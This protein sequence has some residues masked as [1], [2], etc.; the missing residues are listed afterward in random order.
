MSIS[1]V[2]AVHTP[3]ASHVRPAQTRNP[4]PDPDPPSKTDRL[5]AGKPSAAEG[6]VDIVDIKV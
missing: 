3:H 1:D 2:G 5:V 6:H 4:L